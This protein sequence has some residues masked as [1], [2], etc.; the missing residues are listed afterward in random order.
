MDSK[1]TP[2]ARQRTVPKAPPVYRPTVSAARPAAPPV[3]RPAAVQRSP[4]KASVGPPVYRPALVQGSTVQRS[5][6]TP[7]AGPPVYRPVNKLPAVPPPAGRMARLAQPYRPAG[8]R[9]IPHAPPRMTIRNPIQRTPDER[10]ALVQ[11]GAMWFTIAE[12]AK[13]SKEKEAYFEK[14]NQELGQIG[15]KIYTVWHKHDPYIGGGANKNYVKIVQSLQ[16]NDEGATA[17]AE[18]IAWAE[19]TTT[20]ANLSQNL[21]E[22]V[23]IVHVAEVGRGYFKAAD[24]TLQFMKAVASAGSGQARTQLWSQFKEVLEFAKTSKEDTEYS[25]DAKFK[26]IRGSEGYALRSH[27]Q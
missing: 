15:L 25:D 11:C 4:Q 13:D 18:Y 23:V 1:L 9:A 16:G 20:L 14:L 19:G 26:H 8:P 21:Q 24:E 12:Q 5:P 10:K 27:K 7:P 3:Y 22:L 17:A 6:L 2:P